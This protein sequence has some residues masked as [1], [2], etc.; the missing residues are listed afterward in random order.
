MVSPERQRALSSAKSSLPLCCADLDVTMA[1]AEA[2]V[3]PEERSWGGSKSHLLPPTGVT[4]TL[5]LGCS[6]GAQGK[7]QRLQRGNFQLNQ[8]RDNRPAGS[9]SFTR[10]PGLHP[11]RSA[12]LSGA[13]PWAPAA[14]ARPAVTGGRTGAQWLP[15]CCGSLST[16]VPGICR[17]LA[18]SLVHH[19]QLPNLR[20]L[21]YHPQ[22]ACVLS[23][24]M[25]WTVPYDG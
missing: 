18:P 4:G 19:P 7:G 5:E 13:G 2:L 22:V 17:D 9:C 23:F 16:L 3:T 15:Q 6:G 21:M 1:E 11:Q 14:A 10:Y 24:R 12:N 20:C 8:V 25:G